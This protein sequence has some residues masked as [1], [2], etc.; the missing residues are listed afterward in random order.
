MKKCP[1]CKIP[2]EK[3]KMTTET[4]RGEFVSYEE[5]WKCPKCQIEVEVENQ[6]D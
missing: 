6:G 2:M 5:Y 3:I 1:D 4:P